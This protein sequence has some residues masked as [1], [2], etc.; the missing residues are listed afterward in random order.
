MA[1]INPVRNHNINY[2]NDRNP[3]I[4]NRVKVAHIITLLELGGAQENTLYT[5]EHLDKNKFDVMLICGKGGILDDKTKN[6]KTYFVKEL[7]REI[8]P[9]YD[10]IAFIKIYKILKYEKPDIIHTHSSKAGILGRWSVWFLRTMNS[11][12]RTIKIIH[13]FHGFGFNDEQN[14]FVRKIYILAERLTAKITD[15]LIAVSCENISCGLK[16]KIGDELQY[17]MIRSGIKLQDYQIEIEIEKKKK[18]FGIKNEHIVGMIACFKKQK[19]PLDFVKVAGLVCNE[20]PDIKFMLVG[21]GVLRKRIEAEIKKLNLEKNVILTGWRKDTNEIMKIFDVFVLT[22]L[23][24]GLPRV[25]VESMAAGIPVVATYIDGTREIVQEGLTGFVVQPHETEKMAER[26]LRL[27]ND[28]DLR[29][30]FSEEAKKRVQEFDID[31]MVSQQEKLY[32]SY[33]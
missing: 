2:T 16:N 5:C 21:D 14:Y 20:K 23:W 17:T 24:E 9:L 30:K 27:L 18:E 4:S 3:K 19:A 15:K 7:I 22:S 28:A 29:K 13:T 11:E 31:L 1:K 26:I 10:L 32:L 12:L 25:I 8:C 33:Q 6:I